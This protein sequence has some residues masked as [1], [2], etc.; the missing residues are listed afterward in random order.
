MSPPSFQFITVIRTTEQATLFST[1]G[2]LGGGRTQYSRMSPPYK[3]VEEEENYIEA[4]KEV[5]LFSF[6]DCR[7]LSEEHP[8]GFTH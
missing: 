6:I 7:M 8:F 1:K 3:R 2:R 4:P 5:N